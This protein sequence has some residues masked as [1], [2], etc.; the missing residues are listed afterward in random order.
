MS[1]Y[2]LPTAIAYFASRNSTNSGCYSSTSNLDFSILGLWSSHH[3]EHHHRISHVSQISAKPWLESKFPTFVSIGPSETSKATSIYS[4]ATFLY[5]TS[6]LQLCHLLNHG[7]TGFH[8]SSISHF[9]AAFWDL[10]VDLNF[11]FT[12]SEF[13]TS[14]II[15]QFCYWRIPSAIPWN[16]CLFLDIFAF[17][18][19]DLGLSDLT[20]IP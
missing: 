4:S 19:A 9:D 3:S 17:G 8:T 15:V 1:L 7:Q 11:H 14:S 10:Q 5:S 12:R 16:P 20:F 2:R 18:P 6:S 13:I